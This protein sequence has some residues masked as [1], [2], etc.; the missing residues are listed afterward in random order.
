MGA[1]DRRAANGGASRT[2]SVLRDVISALRLAAFLAWR[3]VRA[4]AVCRRVL[5]LLAASLVIV[6]SLSIWAEMDA[7]AFV[8]HHFDLSRDRSLAEIYGY[9]LSGTTALLL[10]GAWRRWGA[11]LYLAFSLLFAF[12]LVDDAF[13][14]HENMARHV[15]KPL[16]DLPR[17]PGLRLQD[18]GELLAWAL[19]AFVLAIPAALALLRPATNKLAACILLAIPAALLA[20]FA[21]G[22]DM[23]HGL[24][25]GYRMKIAAGLIEDG[26][27]LCA[28]A[29]AATFSLIA[30]RSPLS[31]GGT[32]GGRAQDAHAQ[33]GI[34]GRPTHDPLRPPA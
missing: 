22:A 1:G 34:A 11:P 29:L 15:L 26:G 14:Y 20:G 2:R 31:T 4:D 30:L 21:I 24:A 32:A 6:L 28:L 12:A 13:S 5:P 7:P 10:L 18:T 8:A 19:A 23:V 33:R 3:T 9:V 27:E 16:F 17:L 25:D